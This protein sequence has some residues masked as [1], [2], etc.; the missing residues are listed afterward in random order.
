MAD[1]G[2]LITALIAGTPEESVTKVG[3]Y[4]RQKLDQ[5]FVSPGG[6]VA[7]LGDAAHPQ[8][9]FLGQGCNMALADAFGTCTRLVH[10]E[11]RAALRALDDPERK[12]FCKKVVEDARSA[13]VRETKAVS[14]FTECVMKR[15]MKCVPQ[16]IRKEEFR[17]YHRTDEGNKT[18]MD[19]A[20][21]ACVL[22]L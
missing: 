19:R 16:S 15:Y 3:L 4:D 11:V 22:P 14:C 12:A 20:L 7:L 6:R 5:P 8:T 2:D 1:R 9:P 21:T 18:F 17:S 10:Q 13:A